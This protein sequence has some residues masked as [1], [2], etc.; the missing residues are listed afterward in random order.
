MPLVIALIKT[1]SLSFRGGLHGLVLAVV[2]ED[3]EAVCGFSFAIQYSVNSVFASD[4]LNLASAQLIGLRQD[5]GITLV[6]TRYHTLPDA[7]TNFGVWLFK[8]D[9]IEETS[10]KG[11]VQIGGEVCRCDEDTVQVFHLLQDDV[12]DGIFHLVQTPHHLPQQGP[13]PRQ[14]PDRR[15]GKE[16]RQGVQ[17]RVDPIWLIK[18]PRLASSS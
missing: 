14:L 18:V 16:R 12:L 7:A 5:I 2:H 15:S 10:L 8:L 17:R 1:Y 11:A 13:Q 3:R 4:V 9:F 6:Q